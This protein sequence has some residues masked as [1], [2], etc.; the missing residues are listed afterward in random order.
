MGVRG[1][2]DAL[3]G[4]LRGRTLNGTASREVVPG[5]RTRTSRT[6]REPSKPVHDGVREPEDT[7]EGIRGM[8]MSLVELNS[9]SEAE[10]ARIAKAPALRSAP[11]VPRSGATETRDPRITCLRRR[12][13]KRLHAGVALGNVVEFQGVRS[14]TL[15]R[16][17]KFW[18]LRL[19]LTARQPDPRQEPEVPAQPREGVPAG[20]LCAG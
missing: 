17:S 13:V 4:S 1:R 18:R 8:R 11:G 14:S 6:R 20:Y 5:S 7:L 10:R 15:G 16:A 2:R 12:D 3:L 19:L 9:S